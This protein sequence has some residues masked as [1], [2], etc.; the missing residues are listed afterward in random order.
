MLKDQEFI[1]RLE[2][3]RELISIDAIAATG[4]IV[5]DAV[6]I[7]AKGIKDGD[8]KLA[9][10]FLKETG[11]LRTT[12]SRIGM[13]QKS[14]DSDHGLQILINISGEDIKTNDKI[15]DLECVENDHLDNDNNL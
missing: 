4:Q 3:E 7:V 5:A 13:D 2:Q 15:I 6:K 11:V 12:G 10:D 14:A 8:R 9:F 1:D